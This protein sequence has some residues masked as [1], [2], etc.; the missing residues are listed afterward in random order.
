[1]H[2]GSAYVSMAATLCKTQQLLLMLRSAART[3]DSIL[4]PPLLRSGAHNS[5]SKRATQYSL[6]GCHHSIALNVTIQ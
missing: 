1:M 3:V 6:Y 2:Y 4:Q 5:A